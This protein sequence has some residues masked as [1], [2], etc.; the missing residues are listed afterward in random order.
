MLHSWSEKSFLRS[1]PSCQ[2]AR[3]VGV[4]VA[5]LVVGV[6]VGVVVALLV[7]GVEVGVVLGVVVVAG[8]VVGVVLF[9]MSKLTY[10]LL[11]S[12]MQGTGERLF[13]GALAV[14]A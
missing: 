9:K 10:Q 3:V 14:A 7:V 8:L 13:E 1:A 2:P 4:V 5:L 12:S 11:S 6:D